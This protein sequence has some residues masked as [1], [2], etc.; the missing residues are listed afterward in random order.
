MDSKDFKSDPLSTV[1]LADKQWGVCWHRQNS[2]S[3]NEWMVLTKKA[4]DTPISCF[5]DLTVLDL[6][7]NIQIKA[8][9]E[10]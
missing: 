6:F 9:I 5:A 7:Y 1:A 2:K 4:P 10:C 8:V 3:M